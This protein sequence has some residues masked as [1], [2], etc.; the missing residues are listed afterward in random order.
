MGRVEPVRTKGRSLRRQN[1]TMQI[2]QCKLSICIVQFPYAREAFPQGS[3][4][5][6]LSFAGLVA[7]RLEAGGRV[8]G[9]DRG[10]SDG[11]GGES[12]PR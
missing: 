9:F 5:A 4:E 1:C 7:G 6:P 2:A 3:L 8:V 11:D 10:A 12:G